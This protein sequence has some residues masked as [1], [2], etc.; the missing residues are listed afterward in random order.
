MPV[1]EDIEKQ[2]KSFLP[3]DTGVTEI[4]AEGP[5]IVMYTDKPELF[6]DH[7]EIAKDLLCPH[8]NGLIVERAE[9]RHQMS[10]LS[11]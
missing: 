1:L 3:S 8:Q 11:T 10:T 5:K 9:S 7:P 2:I 6:V 4:S